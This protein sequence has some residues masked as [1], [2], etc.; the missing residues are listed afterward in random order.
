MA[1]LKDKVVLVTGAG[2]GLGRAE[3]RLLAKLGAR[4]VLN[5]VGCD[6]EGEGADPAVV[7]AIAGEA[8]ALGAE[9]VT[10]A[11]DVAKE[12]AAERLVDLA[13]ASFGRLDGLVLSAGIRRDRSLSKVTRADLDRM[14]AV[15]VRAGFELTRAASAA[16]IGEGHGGS[17]VLSTSPSA[18]FGTARKTL[19]AICASAI[20]GFVRS[21]AVEL[22]RHGVRVNAVAATART[23]MTED[24][25][26]FRGI[27]AGSM[28][29]EHVAPLVAFLLSD[30]AHEV[31]GD[32][33]GVAG[34]RI[35]A[36]QSR[37]TTGAFVEGRAFEPDEILRAF[38]DI[39]RG[40]APISPGDR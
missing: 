30:E 8:R 23:R 13:R 14:L 9:V 38:A 31:Q 34:G 19:E 21:A 39:T 3:A 1:M 27:A 7:E 28:T 4:L 2:G 11:E 24:S 32:V 26:L 33:L 25:P 12:G 36:L 5:D 10:S 40:G 18:F 20:A 6:P 15:H 35:Y 29:P 16:M 22:R 37:E 17:V